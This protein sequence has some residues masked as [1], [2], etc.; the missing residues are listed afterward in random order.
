MASPVCT[1]ALV[2]ALPG[3]T[4]NLTTLT[5]GADSGY[6]R[7]DYCSVFGGVVRRRFD[8][9][10]QLEGTTFGTAPT[11]GLYHWGGFTATGTDG[12]DLSFPL[13]F[14]LE[15]STS[16]NWTTATSCGVTYP[17]IIADQKLCV[18]YW[19]GTVS[20]GG[21]QISATLSDASVAVQTKT[22]PGE[23]NASFKVTFRAREPNS[24]LDVRITK[25]GSASG[26]INPQVRYLEAPTAAPRPKGLS[27]AHL[28][29][30]Q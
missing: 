5:G 18:L 19:Y 15:Q 17:A 21:Y 29:D 22:I 26:A 11:T 6:T 28:H 30:Y 25:T 14:S 4:V 13:S 20:G 27:F 23:G 7:A 12:Y 3:S 24:T 9:G 16:Y 8:G 2:S 10:N 1:I